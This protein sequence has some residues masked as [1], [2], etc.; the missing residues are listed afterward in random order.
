[1]RFLIGEFSHESNYFC[2]HATGETDFKAWELNWDEQVVYESRGKHTV[3]GGFI[4]GLADHQIIGSVAAWAVPS[5]PVDE[6]F[7]NKIK[8][9]LIKSIYKNLPLDGVLLSLHGAMSLESKSIILDPEGDLIAS[10]RDTVHDQ[11]P[12]IAVFDLHSDTSDLLLK[13]ADITLA[14]NEEPHRDAYERGLEAALLIQRLCK[15]EIHPTPARVRVPMLLPAIN[16]ATDTGPMFDLHRL[17]A[18]FEKN[19]VVIDISIHAGFY[20]ADQ[21]EVGFSVVCTT[22]NDP[23]L[24]RHLAHNIAREAWKKREEFIIPVTPIDQAIHQALITEEPI[25]L[26]DEADDP[27]GGASADSVA[28]LRGMLAGGITAGGMSTIKDTDITHY[29]SQLGEGSKVKVLLGAKTDH[30]HG[31]PI[32][33]EGK[34]VKISKDPIPMDTWSGRKYNVGIIAVLD[35]SGILVV[36]TEQKLVTENIDIFEILGFD[37]R[38]MKAVGFKGLGLHIRQALKGKISIF[39]PVDGIGITHPNVRK[40]GPYT[41]VH[42][43][44]WPLD[45]FAIDEYFN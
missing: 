24:A 9:Y 12:I 25:G 11:V 16:M 23:D 4:D 17:R 6:A 41:R 21:P 3:L 26:I 10:I 38:N 18:E 45:E 28:I 8:E 19:P 29:L 35:V 34:V 31:E 1:V 33:V 30:L 20:G 40:L 2:A 22:D 27:A 43:P 36:I 7:Y 14:Y 42:R 5:G 44:I 32:L 15:G 37:V 13:N 39:I